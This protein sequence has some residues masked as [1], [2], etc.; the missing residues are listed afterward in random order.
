[1]KSSLSAKPEYK[2]HNFC[3]V[4]LSDR[5]MRITHENHLNR[6]PLLISVLDGRRKGGQD[7]VNSRSAELIDIFDIGEDAFHSVSFLY[8]VD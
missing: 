1:M 4:A 8:N 3:I 7:I 6:C 2:F 5:I